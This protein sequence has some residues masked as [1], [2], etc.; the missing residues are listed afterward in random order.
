MT[1]QP[2]APLTVEE[3]PTIY[4]DEARTYNT[5]ENW[6]Q[7]YTVN[8][9]QGEYIHDEVTTN[10]IESVWAILKR[11]HK[12]IYHQW[13][14]KH[15]PQA[16]SPQSEN[17]CRRARRH[18]AE[19]TRTNLPQSTSTTRR[20]IPESPRSQPKSATIFTSPSMTSPATSLTKTS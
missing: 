15:G 6:Y 11:A 8:R 3:G 9:K 14:P 4:S 10:G 20:S 1:T 12:G 19:V 17:R 5:L 18:R 13:R 7:H 2:P 16:G